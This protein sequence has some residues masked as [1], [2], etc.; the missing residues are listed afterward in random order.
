[1]TA[2]LE[3]GQPEE[4]YRVAVKGDDLKG[5]AATATLFKFH[6]CAKRAIEAEDQYR[7]LLIARHSAV[8]QWSRNPSFT[9]MRKQLSALVSRTRT[10]MI[11]L[12]AQDANIQLMFGSQGWKWN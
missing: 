12:S 6:G 2:M 1:E 7:D 3:L 10:L 5:P 11:G 9:E 4:T 8:S